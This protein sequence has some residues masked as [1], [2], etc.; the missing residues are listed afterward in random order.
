[1]KPALV[2]TKRLY[3]LL[4]AGIVLALAGAIVPGLEL[5]A[6]LYTFL[7]LAF[8]GISYLVARK[9]NP[10]EISRNVSPVLAVRSKNLV[11]LEFH[12][13]SAHTVRAVVRE[14]WPPDANQ[15]AEEQQIKLAPMETIER[16]YAVRPEYRGSLEVADT[17]VRLEAPLGLC[18]VQYAL[19][20][21]QN[22]AVYPNIHRVKE[23]ELL[24]QK[25]Q[26]ALMG[27]RKSRLKGMGTEFE[28]LRDY[29]DDDQ[30]LV[31]WK[32]SARRGKLVVKNLE[33]ERN[34]A[35]IICLDVG[36]HMIAEVEGVTKLDHVMDSMLMLLNAA[37][38]AGDQ[39]GLMM[40]SDIVHR[41]IPPKK[42]RAQ[43]GTI[44]NSVYNRHAEPVQ[45][46]YARAFAYLDSRWKR[47]A[48]VVVF[49]D[50]EDE[51]QAAD[52]LQGMGRIAKKHVVMLVRVADPRLRE[53]LRKPIDKYDELLEA[54][55][56]NWYLHERKAAERL[57]TKA[58]V[59]SVEA[60][61]E[62]LAK[63]LLAHYQE[64]KARSL[65]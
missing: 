27:M 48:L 3:A 6:Y 37:N 58:G 17:Q 16:K 31:D 44:L 54:A 19:P 29:H 55:S 32:A 7:L 26:L 2:P 33:A 34:Q 59:R 9:W 21:Q 38:V 4:I 10:M 12:N 42:G 43:I 40:Y 57:L 28:S 14:T 46:D 53:L 24:R 60:E 5:I 22:L 61:P 65:I 11:E 63:T 39:I 51:A 49:T 25:G 35:V 47:R 23:F 50:A 13:R 62:E 45:P 41:Y 8:T 56:V 20:N 1:M 52:L 36:R 64:I 30:R 15:D 18:Y